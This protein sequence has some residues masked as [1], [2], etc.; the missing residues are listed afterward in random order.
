MHLTVLPPSRGSTNDQ[1]Q[2][3]DQPSI[4]AASLSRAQEFTVEPPAPLHPPTTSFVQ[5]EEGSGG[6]PFQTTS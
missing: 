3:G 5:L 6:Q 4:L 2:P 1:N